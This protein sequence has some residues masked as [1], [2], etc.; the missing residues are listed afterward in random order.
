MPDYLYDQVRKF[1]KSGEVS[2]FITKAVQDWIKVLEAKNASVSNYESQ[3]FKVVVFAPKKNTDQI[4]EAMAQAGAGVIGNYTHNAF[5]TPGFG[6]WKSEEG[7]QPYIGEV[8]RMSREPE[9]RIE[10][11][12]PE[13]KLEMVTSAAKKNHPYETPVIEVYK[14]ESV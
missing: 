2:Q 14:I 13:E 8:G 4:I 3:M 1:A 10:M 7:A 9:N 6:N 12:C 11:A 5:I